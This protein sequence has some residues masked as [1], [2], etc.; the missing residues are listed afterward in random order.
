VGFAG[1]A[2]EHGP[3]LPGRSA[4]SPYAPGVSNGGKGLKGLGLHR[5][6]A[7]AV[8]AVLA[9]GLISVGAMSVAADGPPP[10][11]DGGMSFGEIHGPSDPEEYSWTVE[12][13]EDQVLRAIDDQ[14][15]WVSEDGHAVMAITAELASDADGTAV[16]TTL[17]VSG[18]D[19][20]TLTVHHRAGNPAAGGAPFAYPIVGGPGWE[21]GFRTV[22]VPMSPAEPVA[23]DST[24]TLAVTPICVVP[25]LKGASV[26]ASRLKLRVGGCELGEIRGTRSKTAKVVRQYPT[27]GT[28]RA[29]GAEVAVKLGG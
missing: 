2:A 9:F 8:V 19:V 7:L 29:V 17:A 16:P 18:R 24:S 27:P 10:L 21:G 15:A 1:Q 4:A 11:S 13:G 6:A 14:H 5:A 28:A 23:G 20:I 3:I 25:R 12:L 26:A 22:Y